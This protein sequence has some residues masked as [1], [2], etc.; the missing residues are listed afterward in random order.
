MTVLIETVWDPPTL[1]SIRLPPEAPTGKTKGI[2]RCQLG[3]YVPHDDKRCL[4]V[5]NQH[6]VKPLVWFGITVNRF[7]VKC[8]TADEHLTGKREA[9]WL[10]WGYY[11]CSG[12]TQA[13]TPTL[14]KNWPTP[15]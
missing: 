2:A 12:A 14:V 8:P 9:H 7:E 13:M 6:L 5:S 15:R 3:S 10:I 4:R 1:T 11:P